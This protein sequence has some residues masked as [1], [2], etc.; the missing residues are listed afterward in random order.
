MDH[1]IKVQLADKDGHTE[2]MLS[3]AETVE[4][5]QQN[6]SQWV[7]ADGHMVNANQI[8]EANLS[9]VS[10]VRVLPGLVGG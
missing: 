9:T 7:F 2:L 10:T 3:P 6:S 8:D 1:L 4:T 5:L